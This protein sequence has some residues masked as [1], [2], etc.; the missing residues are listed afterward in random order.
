MMRALLQVQWGWISEGETTL[1]SW[2]FIFIRRMLT[3]FSIVYI[4]NYM[5]GFMLNGFLI[6]IRRYRAI[7]RRAASIFHI[8]HADG[9]LKA[10]H[11]SKTASKVLA[12][13]WGNDWQAASL[14]ILY[15]VPERIKIISRN[16]KY[17]IEQALRKSLTSTWYGHLRIRKSLC[18]PLSITAFN[19]KG[20]TTNVQGKWEY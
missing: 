1:Y 9:S 3:T 20:S 16:P 10:C 19:G 18:W 11:W 8:H 15:C 6:I 17:S 5:T 13:N 2:M 7:H 4:N 14:Y 12:T